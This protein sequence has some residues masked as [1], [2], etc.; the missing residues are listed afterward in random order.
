MV[1][2]FDSA[3]AAI[4]EYR[5]LAK[6]G[7]ERIEIHAYDSNGC[8][9]ISL[10]RLEKIFH[11]ERVAPKRPKHR[12]RKAIASALLGMVASALPNGFDDFGVVSGYGTVRAARIPRLSCR[13]PSGCDTALSVSR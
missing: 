6:S 1:A 10:H 5:R 4:S 12:A 8:T 2:V 13:V 7:I 9:K 11:A 3:A